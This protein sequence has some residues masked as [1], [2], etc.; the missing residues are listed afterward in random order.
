MHA[1]LFEIKGIRTRCYEIVT[2]SA[3]KL[4]VEDLSKI[5]VVNDKKRFITQK[6][7]IDLANFKVNNYFHVH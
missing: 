5:H 3:A 7:H 6:Q 4:E 1:G 2:I